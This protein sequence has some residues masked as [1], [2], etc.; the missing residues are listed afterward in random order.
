[1]SGAGA[2]IGEADWARAAEL[3]HAAGR[4]ALACHVSPDGDALGSMLGLGLALRRAGK[5][6]VASFGDRD[7]AVPRMLRFLPGRELLVAPSAFPAEPEL[8]ITCDASSRERL[9][10]LEPN[11]ARAGELIVIDHHASNT[12]FGSVHLVDP[13]APATTVLVAEL[14]DRLGIE[15]DREVATCL[16]TGLVTDTGSFRHSSATPAAHA[17]AARLIAKGVAPDEIARALF[18]S[19]PYGYL[20]VLGTALGRAA[21]EPSAAAGHGLIWTYVTREDRARY[22]LPYDELEGV[23]D[24]VRRADAADV[25]VVLKETDDGEWHASVRSRCAVDVG[26]ACAALGG[27]GHRRAAGFATSLPPEQAIA[28]LRPH[29]TAATRAD[30]DAR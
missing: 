23:I 18:D 21:L 24:V 26:R 5:D 27:G 22:A 19:V 29:L 14:L 20:H 30:L 11:A 15:I 3:V 8:M 25:A 28:A 10:L 7:A 12:G 2:P 1:M 16:Y 4:V 13:E 9:G 17:M 6:V